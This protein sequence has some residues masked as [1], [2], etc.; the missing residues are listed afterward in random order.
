M[1]GSR[2]SSNVAALKALPLF[3][4]CDLLVLGALSSVVRQPAI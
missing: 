2:V 3:A 4:L 1:V